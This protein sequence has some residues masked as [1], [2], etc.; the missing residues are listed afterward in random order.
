MQHI[1]AIIYKMHIIKKYHINM[2]Y[3]YLWII[4]VRYSSTAVSSAYAF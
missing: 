2:R 1:K 4:V 3:S